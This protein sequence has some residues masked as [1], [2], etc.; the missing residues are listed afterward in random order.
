MKS[1]TTSAPVC[2]GRRRFLKTT[3]GLL[4]GAGAS[5]WIY[6]RHARAASPNEKIVI[7]HIGVGGMGNGHVTAF[8]GMADVEVAAICDVD[9]TRRLATLKRLKERKPGCRAEPVAD[10]RRVL[11]RSDIDAITTATPDHWHALVSILA[12]QSGKDV[13]CE[14]PFTHNFVEARAVAAASHRYGRVFQLGTQVHAGENYHRV[15]ELVRSGV[16]GDIRTVRLWKVGGS[17]G[18]GWPKPEEPPPTLDWDMWLGPAPWHPYMPARCHHNFRYFWDY[19]GGSYA[20]FWCHIADLAFWALELKGLR[21]ISARGETPTDGFADTPR[22]I[23]VDFEFDRLP[24]HWTT[25]R[26]DVPGTAGGGIGACFEGTKGCLV[27][28]YNNRAIFLDGREH[29]DIEDVPRTLRRSPGHHRNFLDCI[30]TRGLSDSNA[31]YAFRMATPMYL[32][33]ISF[34]LGRPLEWDATRQQ[35]VGDEA[36]NRMLFRPYRAPWSL[37]V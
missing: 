9:E 5:G 29:R 33:G 27:A 25:K 22:W 30:K 12:M 8:A 3:G 17:P 28:D 13:Y 14:K 37:P 6:P 2:P 18:L 21:K 32:G 35:F 11:E 1:F 24:V 19:S 26:P 31:A 10:F 16:L 23:D 20:D 36:A 34:R 7:A 15:V 4:L